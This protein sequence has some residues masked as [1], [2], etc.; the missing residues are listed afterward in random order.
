MLVPTFQK[1]ISETINY[2]W[3]KLQFNFIQVS[4]YEISCN[5]NLLWIT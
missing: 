3:K 4:I 5:S 2:L 1:N